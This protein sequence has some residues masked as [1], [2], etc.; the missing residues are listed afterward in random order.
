[1]LITPYFSLS[2]T[3][4]RVF[5]PHSLDASGNSRSIPPKTASDRWGPVPPV[6]HGPVEVTA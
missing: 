5:A 6:T 2:K 4:N 3:A 1:M